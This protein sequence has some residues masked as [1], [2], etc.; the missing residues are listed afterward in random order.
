MLL[1]QSLIP[2]PEST[3]PLVVQNKTFVPGLTQLAL[4]DETW[5]STRWGGTGNLWLLHVY[6]PAQNPGDA[7]GVNQFGRWAYGPWF[8]KD[9]VGEPILKDT[10]IYSLQNNCNRLQDCGMKLAIHC[11]NE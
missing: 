6:S 2:G 1:D 4:E 3:I 9:E 10:Y 7:S 11:L 8:W 5:D